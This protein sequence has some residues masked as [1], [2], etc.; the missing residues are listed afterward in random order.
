ML[1]RAISTEGDRRH[2]TRQST[3]VRI[4]FRC[5]AASFDKQLRIAGL[6]PCSTTPRPQSLSVAM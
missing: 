3:D 1:N 5:S 6:S 2:P 4:S